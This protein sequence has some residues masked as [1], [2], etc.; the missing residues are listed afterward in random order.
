MSKQH[1]TQSRAVS[2]RWKALVLLGL[3]LS[4][5]YGLVTLISH[6]YFQQQFE[7]ERHAFRAENVRQLSA[8]TTGSAQKLIQLAETLPL[9][10]PQG[11]GMPLPTA[12][13]GEQLQRN[14]TRMQLVWELELAQL[15]SAQGT[16]YWQRGR[17]LSAPIE[18]WVRQASSQ[19]IPNV[20]FHCEP[21]CLQIVSVPLIVG[22]QDKAVLV[23]GRNLADFLLEYQTAVGADVGILS[24]DQDSNAPGARHLSNW[25]LQVTALTNSP[26][27]VPTLAATAADHPLTA[28]AEGGTTVTD[29]GHIYDVQLIPISD[30]IQPSAYFAVIKDI[31]ADITAI[32]NRTRDTLLTG[33]LGITVAT[34]LLAIIFWSQAARLQRVTNSLP[35][36]A[37]HAYAR[38]RKIL[39]AST[40]KRRWRDEIDILAETASSLVDQ[41]ENL[42]IDVSRQSAE[43]LEQH[44]ALLQERDFVASLLNHAQAIIF[45]QDETGRITMIN[46]FGCELLGFSETQLIGKRFIDFVAD[47]EQQQATRTTIAELH[48]GKANNRQQEAVIR[49]KDGAQRCISWFHS[50]LQHQVDDGSLVLSVGLDLTGRKQAEEKLAWLADHDELTGMFNRRRF[51]AELGRAIQQASRYDHQGAVLYLDL[52][53]FKYINDTSGHHAGDNLLKL[54]AEKI[55]K[56]LRDT[57]IA[58][59]VGG[60]EFAVILQETTSDHAELTARK[61]AAALDELEFWAHDHRHRIAASI[62]IALFPLHGTSVHD[63]MANADLAM[64]H[65]K[66]NGRAKQHLFSEN[67]QARE[68]MSQHLIWKTRIEQALADDRFIF[69]FQP[70]LHIGEGTVSHYE[71]LLRMVREDGTVDPP[72]SFIGVAEATGL[73]REIDQYVVRAGVATLA[74]WSRNGFSATISLNLSGTMMTARELLVPLLKKEVAHYG[75]D[76]GRII[77]EVTETAAV[78]DMASARQMMLDIK[79]LGCRFALDDFGVGLSSFSYLQQLPVD[80]IKIDGAFIR[81][82]PHREDNQLFVQALVQVAHGLGRQTVAEFV[83]DAPTLD[84]L[85]KLGVNYAQGF[86]IG[87][88]G[89]EPQARDSQ[90]QEH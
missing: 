86:H 89:A 31:S 67:E 46:R 36:L 57:D 51:Q 33:I 30:N 20:K 49:C 45:T 41:L 42:E 11:T 73:I 24:G 87:R 77:F 14:W 4:V 66:G 64:Y 12:R 54:V 27:T 18:E 85:Q 65:A 80:Y 7:Q 40:T 71:A 55:T 10:E 62:G 15:H 58:A 9:L 68:L 75:V 13:I 19:E 21:D 56:T 29:G 90:R 61:L 37:S 26:R 22:E 48:H 1:L 88:P 79:Q 44:A 69:H 78:L 43:L 52:D 39:A 6:H 50:A 25:G 60:D 81:D 28:V 59:R 8:L 23:L 70:I 35:L 53:H 16:P 38:A 17:Q 76:P 83:E 5:T 2:L 34:A 72:G 47:Q 3:T 32:R 74:E 82:L 63:L 84:M